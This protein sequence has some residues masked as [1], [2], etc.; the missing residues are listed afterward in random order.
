MRNKVCDT[1]APIVDVRLAQC[2]VVDSAA[3]LPAV[4]SP[5]SGWNKDLR[6]LLSSQQHTRTYRPPAVPGTQLKRGHWTSQARSVTR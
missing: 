6:M 3:R 5:Q 2:C 4:G 1:S